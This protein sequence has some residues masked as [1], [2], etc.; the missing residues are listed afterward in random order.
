MP[1]LGDLERFAATIIY[2]WRFAIA[3]LAVAA[4]VGLV[5]LA[6][7]RGWLSAARRHPGRMGALVARSSQHTTSMA[8]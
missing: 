6:A 7:R 3:A 4:A 1:F 8:G 5:V 2:P